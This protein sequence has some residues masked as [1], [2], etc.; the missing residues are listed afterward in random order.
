MIS[1]VQYDELW[2]AGLLDRDICTSL[3]AGWKEDLMTE[4]GR[5]KKRRVPVYIWE[6]RTG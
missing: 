2:E 3:P 6:F 4:T 5:E 1:Y